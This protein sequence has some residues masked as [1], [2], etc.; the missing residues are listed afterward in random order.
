MKKLISFV[1][2]GLLPLFMIRGE[3]S[4]TTPLAERMDELG[5]PGVSVA[6]IDDGKIAWAR[7]WGLADVASGRPVTIELLPESATSF[8][9]RL[10]GR[11]VAFEFEGDDVVIVAAGRRG[12]KVGG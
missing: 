12:Q 2:I 11:P 9:V 3:A 8:F 4:D 10:D 1:F 7:G 6:V 5:V